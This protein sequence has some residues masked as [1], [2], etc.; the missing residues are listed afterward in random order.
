M[1]LFY[2]FVLLLVCR[3][4]SRRGPRVHGKESLTVPPAG[5]A[6]ARSIGL[7]AGLFVF[8][9][10]FSR[11]EK[12]HVPSSADAISVYADR[13]AGGDRDHRDPHRPAAAR[14]AESPR[15]RCARQVPEQSQADH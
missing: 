8:L 11:K 7:T 3:A 1:N 10:L 4:G 5:S 9:F 14:R 15:G 6:L 13:T 12:F 2:P